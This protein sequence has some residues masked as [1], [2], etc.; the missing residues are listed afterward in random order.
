MLL[1]LPRRRRAPSSVLIRESVI[2]SVDKLLACPRAARWHQALLPS[3]E[4]AGA[5][6]T[7]KSS[8][9]EK[10]ISTEEILNLTEGFQNSFK[11]FQIPFKG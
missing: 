3:A 2:E 10:I 8:T 5:R 6:L 1:L 11:E 7:I 9:E 4:I